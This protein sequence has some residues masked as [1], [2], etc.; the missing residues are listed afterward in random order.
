MRG[1]AVIVQGVTSG[2]LQ[3][4]WTNVISLYQAAVEG[5][6]FKLIAGGATNVR[7]TNETHALEVLKDSPIKRAKDLEGKT[8]AVNTLNNIVHL[9]AMAWVDKNGGSSAKVKFIELPFPQ[10]EAA[11]VAG[12]IDAISV[13]EPFAAAA[14]H[15]P[16]IRVLSNPWGD[17]LPK[18]L[19]ASWFAS[20]KWMQ[21][22]RKTAEAFVRAVNRGIDAIHTDKEGAR[23]AMIKWAGLKP[24]MVGKI[25]MPLFD[26]ALSQKDLQATIDLTV[27]YKFISRKLNAREVISDLAP[28][29]G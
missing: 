5:F 16:E 28:T 19:I 21:K 3:F 13:Q 26:K 15:K 2:D 14:A 29:K 7:G 20:E 25:G 6:D 22:N 9:M 4:G 23:A 11:L 24:D 17:V 8:V 12:K 27:K 18:F 1:G 10:M